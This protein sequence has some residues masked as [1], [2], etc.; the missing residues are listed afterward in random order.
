MKHIILLEPELW[1][2]AEI[3]HFKQGLSFKDTSPTK[4]LTLKQLHLTQ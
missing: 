1:E 4:L 2:W 3:S